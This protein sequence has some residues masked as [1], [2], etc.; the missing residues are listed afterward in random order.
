M[1][2]DRRYA[3]RKIFV[4]RSHAKPVTVEDPGYEAEDERK[5]QETCLLEGCERPLEQPATGRPRE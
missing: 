3:S 2:W 4:C 1:D 5:L